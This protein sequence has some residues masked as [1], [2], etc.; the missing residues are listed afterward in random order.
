MGGTCQL[1]VLLKIKSMVFGSES[2][3]AAWRCVVAVMGYKH[4]IWLQ[5]RVSQTWALAADRIGSD[6]VDASLVLVSLVSGRSLPGALEFECVRSH[7]TLQCL[8]GMQMA[9]RRLLEA[10][11]RVFGDQGRSQSGWVCAV[12][13]T[14]RVLSDE[15]HSHW[16]LWPA[17]RTQ[18]QVLR[19]QEWKL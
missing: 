8:L 9:P 10:R 3:N 19:T 11:L 13:T 1:V 15:R 18:S 16:H 7:R 17:K 14:S 5:N 2:W 4:R 12:T 6:L